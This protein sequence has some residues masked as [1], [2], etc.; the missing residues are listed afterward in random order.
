MMT[1]EQVEE[2]LALANKATGFE[3]LGGGDAVSR[4]AYL[5][6]VDDPQTVSSLATELL[7]LRKRVGELEGALIELQMAGT[8]LNE[9]P[10]DQQIRRRRGGGDRDRCIACNLPFA[11]GELVLSEAGGGLIHAACCGPERESYTGKDGGPLGPDEPIPTGFPYRALTSPAS[12]ERDTP[13][14]YVLVPVDPTEGMLEAGMD[15]LAQSTGEPL[16]FI[17]RDVL[18]AYRA[19]VAAYLAKASGERDAWAGSAPF[20][21]SESGG[22]EYAVRVKVHSM[23]EL[24]AAH[25]IVLKAFGAKL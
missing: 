3:P 10:A 4:R 22:G 20:I 16:S 15:S 13:A 1:T 14:G 17:V 11:G 8:A 7:A 9:L 19:M 5:R 23:D 18:F 6:K 21:T 12:G 24:H 2:I 25:T